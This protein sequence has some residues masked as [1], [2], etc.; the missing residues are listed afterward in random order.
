M[1]NCSIAAMSL[2]HLCNFIVNH[3]QE[4]NCTFL[5]LILFYWQ[6][7]IF[8]NFIF[9]LYNTVLVLPYID[10]N[11]PQVYMCSPPWTLLPPPSP[12][13]PSGSSQCS[14]PEHPVSCIEPGLV[15]HFTYDIICFDA[16]L[17]NHP[18]IAL[19]HWVQKTVLYIC[20]SFAVSY[21][22]LLLSFF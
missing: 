22:G 1:K 9:L 18:T 21:T 12:S 15:I 10:M 14:S 8:F 17:P 13:H 5:L 19:S 20:V 4:V 7:V 3:P 16:I 6:K 2:Y 11:P